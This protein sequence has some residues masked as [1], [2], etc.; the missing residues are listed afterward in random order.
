MNPAA[1]LS[2][3]SGLVCL[4]LSVVF[5]VKSSTVQLLSADLQILQQKIQAEQQS[6]QIQQDA[7]RNQQALINEGVQLA[8][9][10]GPAVLND[11]GLRVRDNKNEKIRALLKKYD[12]TVNEQA[13]TETP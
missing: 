7:L 4:V 13:T 1:L 12:V 8:Q 10:I 11:L 2:T 6:F 9:Q 3:I 5:Y